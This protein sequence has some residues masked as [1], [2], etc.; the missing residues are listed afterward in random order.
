MLNAI[1]T[2]R[3][4]AGHALA[5]LGVVLSCA[6]CAHSSPSTAI[7]EP[8]MHTGATREYVTLNGKDTLGFELVTTCRERLID[9][10]DLLHPSA[11]VHYEADV[12]KD[13]AIVRFTAAIWSGSP[14]VGRDPDE[15]IVH[16]TVE[17]SAVTDVWK[18]QHRQ[19]QVSAGARGSFPYLS[20]YV[21]LLVQLTALLGP[22]EARR[23][24]ARLFY[25]GTGGETGTARVVRRSNDSLTV[26][27][28]DIELHAAWSASSG[29]GGGY[30]AGTEVSY[31][32]MTLPDSIFGTKRCQAPPFLRDNPT[33]PGF[34]LSRLSEDYTDFRT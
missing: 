32:P 8:P 11:H 1:E 30:L 16:H 23:D 2:M 5:A 15:I 22:S 7:G 17:D 20:N 12:A 18:G 14:V 10:A 28:D 13:G 26:R 9:D 34:I 24:S 25:L 27:L 3:P 6:S 19:R 29:F 21:G 31:Q 33:A 4:Q